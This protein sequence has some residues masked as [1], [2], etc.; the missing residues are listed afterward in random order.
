MPDEFRNKKVQLLG[1][2]FSPNGQK[3]KTNFIQKKVFGPKFFKIFF[4][5]LKGNFFPIPKWSD[6]LI[7]AQNW[8]H[9][10]HIAPEGP[11]D[12]IFCM[13]YTSIK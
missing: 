13:K 7:I 4:A 12:W 6:F 9:H 5:Y 8:P 2:A 10:T 1:G 3:G 11:Y